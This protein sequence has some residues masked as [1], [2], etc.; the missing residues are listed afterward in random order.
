MHLEERLFPGA[1]ERYELARADDGDGPMADVARQD[2]C[3][4]QKA[5]ELLQYYLIRVEP[6]TF[7]TALGNVWS[8]KAVTMTR[9]D[10]VT[11]QLADGTSEEYVVEQANLVYAWF[12]YLNPG[13]L[14][15]STHA[16]LARYEALEKTLRS[17]Y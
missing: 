8:S 16:I 3:R 7:R 1:R 2:L 10:A 5:M 17:I 4:K 11:M 13:R 12:L 9:D 6:G 14:G 15:N